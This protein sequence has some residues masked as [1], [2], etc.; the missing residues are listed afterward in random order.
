MRAIA[1]VRR[2]GNVLAL[3]LL[4]SGPVRSAPTY[5]PIKQWG[6]YGINPDQ[7]FAPW[8]IVVD[9][10]QNVYISDNGTQIRK[11]SP[12]G[13]L[14]KYFG[15]GGLNPGCMSH[16]NGIALGS[17]GLIYIVDSGHCQIKMYT[18]S[19]TFVGGWGSCGRNPGQLGNPRGVAI[20]SEGNVYVT[21][22]GYTFDVPFIHKFTSSGTFIQRW[23]GASGSGPDQISAPGPIRIDNNDVLFVGEGANARIH[24]FTTEGVSVGAW[25]SHGSGAGQFGNP[26]GIAIDRNGYVYVADGD[27]HRV[28]VFTHGGEYIAQW[29]T[30]GAGPDQLDVPRGLAIDDASFIYIA[31]S[32]NSRIQKFHE[33]REFTKQIR[34]KMYIGPI[35]LQDCDPIG[36]LGFPLSM[37]DILRQAAY[38]A[39]CRATNL[40]ENPLT[41]AVTTPLDARI[42]AIVDLKWAC[43]PNISLPLAGSITVDRT[44]VGT[45]VLGLSG[46]LNP[47][48]TKNSITSDGRWSFVVSGHP[49]PVVE[50]AFQ[51]VKL[52][53]RGDIWHHVQ[54]KITCS[55][56]GKGDPYS[57]STWFVSGTPFPSHRSYV[58]SYP[59][60][61]FVSVGSTMKQGAFSNLWNLPA[62]DPAIDELVSEASAHTVEAACSLHVPEPPDPLPANYDWSVPALDWCTQL[63][64]CGYD[65]SGCSR[66]YLQEIANP[67]TEAVFPP[68]DGRTVVSDTTVVELPCTE[69]TEFHSGHPCDGS[70]EIAVTFVAAEAT[71]GSVRLRWKSALSGTAQ[72]FRR[73]RGEVWRPIGNAVIGGG[74]LITYEDRSVR[75]G[76]T[77]GYALL[78]QG[79][80][81]MVGETW[82][83]IPIG[84]S[85]A[86]GRPRPNPSS[87]SVMLELSVPS[88][89]PASVDVIDVSGRT[90]I[91]ESVVAGT[92]NRTIV[93]EK[94][95]GLP[96]GVYLIRL[97]QSGM[98]AFQR[99]CIVR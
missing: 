86:I 82:I 97:S 33:G 26:T 3:T 92:G 95:R 37:S 85:F 98:Q 67:I 78:L 96:A 80:A 46:V 88:S 45:E 39:L 14:L 81:E 34:T 13:A 35:S 79:S 5:T 43:G 71:E 11:F 76:G 66:T 36:A 55:T 73:E 20:D 90:V 49:N 22:I 42:L 59:G 52:R 99:L 2:A 8:D 24:M 84:K 53:L 17:N 30:R 1:L 89:S 64:A 94:A 40:Q 28:Q 44:L 47:V 15:C 83:T 61:E 69:S 25:G 74:G 9:N 58:Y 91:H 57:A 38:L 60:E 63:A 87:G 41:G 12:E 10:D 50:V 23:G 56:D 68:P 27:L 16:I 7:F 31:D 18:T 29:G 65:T 62:V 4:I 48:E 75:P 6:S 72:V 93:L 19:G 54:G 51:A 21:D 32:D 77:Y 70:T